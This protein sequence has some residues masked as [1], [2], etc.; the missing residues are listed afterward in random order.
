MGHADRFKQLR[1]ADYGTGL[2]KHQGSVGPQGVS[3]KPSLPSYSLG[4]STRD[5]MYKVR[6][7][8]THVHVIRWLLDARH[9]GCLNTNFCLL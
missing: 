9:L 3:T 7:D 4:A 8:L 6:P 2:F 1:S 5:Q